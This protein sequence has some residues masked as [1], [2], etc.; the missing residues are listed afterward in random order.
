METH[1]QL[2]L[3]RQQRGI[4]AAQLAKLA[5]VTRQ[6]I[7]AIEAGD[8]V[9]NTAVALQMAQILEVRVED[10]FQ[11][12]TDQPPSPPVTVDLLP[13]SPNSRADSRNRRADSRSGR[14]GQPVQL[15]R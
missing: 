5:G 7:Y 6:T 10:L 3:I 12:K 11:L 4:P 1:T 9:P 13:D 2:H 8:Y 14:K 15:C